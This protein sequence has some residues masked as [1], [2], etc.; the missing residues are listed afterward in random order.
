MAAVAGARMGAARLSGTYEAAG[1]RGRGSNPVDYSLPAQ[2]PVARRV[3]FF[4]GDSVKGIEE[5]DAD[6]T[7]CRLSDPAHLAQE[8]LPAKFGAD[9]ACFVIRPAAYHAAGFALWQNFLQRT[10]VLGDPLGYAPPERDALAASRHL[11]ALLQ[12][13][14]LGAGPPAGAGRA[15]AALHP[16]SPRA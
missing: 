11:F 4:V 15:A 9:A 7:I 8:L 6:E 13:L 2:R 16:P 3:L 14:R 12:P 5:A 10:T 1:T